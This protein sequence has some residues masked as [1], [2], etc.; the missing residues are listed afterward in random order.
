MSTIDY[1]TGIISIYTHVYQVAHC[2][3]LYD[4]RQF[5]CTV[6]ILQPDTISCRDYKACTMGSIHV[7]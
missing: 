4:K 2:T 5:K 1:P 3:T 6:Y 7:H